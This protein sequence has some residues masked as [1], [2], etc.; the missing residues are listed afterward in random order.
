MTPLRQKMINTL[1]LK[2]YSPRT[3]KSYLSA[4]ERLAKYYHRSPDTLDPGE[5][6]SYFLYLLTERKLANESVRLT[7]NAVRFL[8]VQVLEQSADDFVVRYPKRAQRIPELL[9]RDDVQ[10]ILLKTAN[11][12]HYTL[13]ATC[14]AAGL[15]VSELVNLAIRDIDS[16]RELLHVRAGKGNKDRA[17]IM[18]PQLHSHLRRYWMAYRPQPYLFE[19]GDRRKALSVVTA[20]KVFTRAKAAAGIDKRGGIHGLRHAFATHQLEAGMPTFKL[21]RLLGH[22]DI[23]S[24][25]RYVHWLPQYQ[26]RGQVGMDLLVW[27]EGRGS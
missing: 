2:G 6:E 22:S 19:S 24:T 13:L 16:E 25:L 3:Q 11:L 9:T 23:K 4:I 1:V 14:Y 5:I 18:T 12:K 21:Q 26:A 8:F 17:V 15:R 27:A 20:Q 10:C 7:V